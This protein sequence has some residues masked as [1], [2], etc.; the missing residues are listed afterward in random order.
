MRNL[1]KDVSR[2]NI[3]SIVNF[4]WFVISVNF[5]ISVIIVSFV[6][7]FIFLTSYSSQLLLY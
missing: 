6:S 7:L 2:V 5:V 4:A 1:N 3:V